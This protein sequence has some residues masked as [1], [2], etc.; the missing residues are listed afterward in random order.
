MSA[1]THHPPGCQC[2]ACRSQRASSSYH[3]GSS[4][5][6]SNP[7]SPQNLSG[8]ARKSSYSNSRSRSGDFSY[9]SDTKRSRIPLQF[10]RIHHLTH[11]RG[12]PQSLQRSFLRWDRYAQ[13]HFV[14]VLERHLA[15]RAGRIDFLAQQEAAKSACTAYHNA[16][17]ESAKALEALNKSIDAISVNSGLLRLANMT[18]ASAQKSKQAAD[19]EVKRASDHMSTLNDELLAVLSGMQDVPKVSLERL[20]ALDE[21]T[22]A[23]C[24]DATHRILRQCSSKFCIYASSNQKGAYPHSSNVSK[25]SHSTDTSSVALTSPRTST[26]SAFSGN[27]SSTASSASSKSG[28]S[29]ASRT[30]HPV[31]NPY[32][33][34]RSSASSAAA[35]SPPQGTVAGRTSANHVSGMPLL[36]N[37]SNQSD[38]KDGEA[39]TGSD[40]RT[41]KQSST[42]VS[43]SS[44]VPHPAPA[45]ADVPSVPAASDAASSTTT[46]GIPALITLEGASNAVTNNVHDTSHNK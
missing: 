17:I 18:K 13:N 36:D 30:Q 20:A 5:F 44:G 12:W 38:I 32:T 19:L 35:T 46:N 39:P 26:N 41:E 42:T 6:V 37:A 29:P 40:Q 45:V 10:Q 3:D 27:T 28:P 11:Y 9:T 2:S 15:L 1:H 22:F 24:V 4:S 43:G 14:Q 31:P 16:T 34:N 33:R 25:S 23:E 7:P 8:H 21:T